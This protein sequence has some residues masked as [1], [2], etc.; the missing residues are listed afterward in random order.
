MPA[1]SINLCVHAHP[2]PSPRSPRASAWWWHPA[3][4][5]SAPPSPPGP[6][7]TTPEQDTARGHSLEEEPGDLS[8]IWAG[9]PMQGPRSMAFHLPCGASP[10]PP[11]VQPPPCPFSTA[12]G[13]QRASA[14][15]PV[16]LHAGVEG[17][18]E[19]RGHG[20]PC[21][22]G[23]TRG[24]RLGVVYTLRS[25]LQIG[26]LTM[27][28]RWC[29]RF[30]ASSWASSCSARARS[31]P[32]SSRKASAW[33]CRS[34]WRSSSAL[35]SPTSAVCRASAATAA[36]AAEACAAASAA[37]ASASCRSRPA[38]RAVCS[39]RECFRWALTSVNWVRSAV[40]CR[41]SCE[42]SVSRRACR[43]S[44]GAW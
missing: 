1:S 20:R 13:R 4:G 36:A 26:A 38:A 6:A 17:L 43:H 11:A 18:R 23:S 34:R 14:A 10:A 24:R 16:A 31:A 8:R 2:P 37:R 29:C 33:A 39:S 27:M 21:L 3:A 41:P 7:G 28:R 32:R 19:V 44:G 35:A 30:S 25:D 9:F 40:S 22:P 12:R 5:P 42:Q 15:G